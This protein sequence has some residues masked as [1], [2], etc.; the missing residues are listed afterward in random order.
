[1]ATTREEKIERL[2]FEKVNAKIKTAGNIVRKYLKHPY[3]HTISIKSRRGTQNSD[4]ISSS[5]I[6]IAG[7]LI[8]RELNSED[9]A[10]IINNLRLLKNQ[11]YQI[12]NTDG[13]YSF[14]MEEK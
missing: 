14:I 1:M 3:Y 5:R 7:P 9:E 8:P 11:K 6:T 2:T 4:G 10:K 12:T 13:V